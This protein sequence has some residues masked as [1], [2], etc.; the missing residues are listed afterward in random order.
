MDE[1]VLRLVRALVT[2][3]SQSPGRFKVTSLH[4]LGLR[5][6]EMFTRVSRLKRRTCAP[7]TFTRR[8]LSR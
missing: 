8:Y 2:K 3:A 7:H 4:T 1:S 6:L 5:V